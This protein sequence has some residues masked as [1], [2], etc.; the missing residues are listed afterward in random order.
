MTRFS[1][2]GQTQQKLYNSAKFGASLKYAN[3][4]KK[5]CEFYWIWGTKNSALEF[6]FASN[7]SDFRLELTFQLDFK[8]RFLHNKIWQVHQVYYITFQFQVSKACI[9]YQFRHLKYFSICSGPTFG[10]Q[11][12]DFPFFIL[13]QKV[14]SF[15]LFDKL[16]NFKQFQN[17]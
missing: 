7:L 2:I 9:W 17:V 11:K 16:D 1:R 13:G 3:S 8:W 5:P 4:N 15:G 10:V 6:V 14:E 12:S